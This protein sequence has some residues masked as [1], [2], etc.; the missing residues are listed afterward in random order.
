MPVMMMLLLSL[1]LPTPHP[2]F[3]SSARECCRLQCH[4]E[5][6]DCRRAEGELEVIQPLAGHIHGLPIHV[7]RRSARHVG[8]GPV[9]G[10]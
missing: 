4:R 10:S 5:Q 6:C 8:G 3:L 9:S 1:M 7:M 2:S